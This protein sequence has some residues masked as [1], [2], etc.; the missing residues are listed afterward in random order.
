MVTLI[1]FYSSSSNKRANLKKVR[2]EDDLKFMLGFVLSLLILI[3][4]KYPDDKFTIKIN[5]VE[6]TSD[7]K[8]NRILCQPRTFIFKASDPIQINELYNLIL[9]STYSHN[10]SVVIII[11]NLT[12][13]S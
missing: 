9:W 10:N 13:M 2:T 11:E 6:L 12:Y 4:D 7:N 8:F 5:I 1:S 3:Y